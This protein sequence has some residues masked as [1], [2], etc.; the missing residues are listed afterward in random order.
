[1]ADL[2]DLLGRLNREKVGYV[3]VGGYATILHGGTVVT[4]DVDICCRF[5]TANLLRLQAA[6]NNLHP[7]H[8]LTP[9]QLPLRLT[10]ASCQGLKNLYLQTDWG[11]VDCLGEVLG[12]GDYA[13]VRKQSILVKLPFGNCRVL[14]LDALIKAKEA[15]GRPHDMQS[16]AQLKAIRARAK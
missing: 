16:V 14:G 3:I 9:K 12:V 8:R 5:T 2:T 7:V 6:L 13:A 15:M 1:M 11:V 4:E 10:P